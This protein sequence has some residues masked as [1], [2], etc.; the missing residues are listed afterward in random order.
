MS[1]VAFG[2]LWVALSVAVLA[3]WYCLHAESRAREDLDR[4]D[5]E[6]WRVSE[7]RRRAMEADDD[8]Q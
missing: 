4:W 1:Y 3:A 5:D 6:M 8:A 2:A 7:G